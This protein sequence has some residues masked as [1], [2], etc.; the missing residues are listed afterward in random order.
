[1]FSAVGVAPSKRGRQR[2][3]N[4]A[5]Q[6]NVEIIIAVSGAVA[7]AV[8][9]VRLLGA[10]IADAGLAANPAGYGVRGRGGSGGTCGVRIL[11]GTRRRVRQRAQRRV[12]ADSPTQ[13]PSFFSR[14]GS[15]A[16]VRPWC[17]CLRLRASLRRVFTSWQGY[18]PFRQYSL[19]K[20]L[21]RSLFRKE[22]RFCIGFCIF[23]PWNCSPY[24][25]CSLRYCARARGSE[26]NY[27]CE[28]K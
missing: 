17:S 1:M 27:G 12:R 19:P 16:A 22:F 4:F 20:S 9:A 11:G 2:H 15:G 28:S 10:R 26:K 13:T 24:R 23:A 14:R 8:V 5:V 3:F 18:V 25:S 21:S 7:A 6:R